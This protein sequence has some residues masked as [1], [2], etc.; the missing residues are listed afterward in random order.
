VAH[1]TLSVY[2]SC[3]PS[4]SLCVCVAH[5][6][7]RSMKDGPCEQV[8]KSVNVGGAGVEVALG[9]GILAPRLGMPGFRPDETRWLVCRK[10]G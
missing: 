6:Y 4:G 5:V 7:V 2:P 9:D 1:L 8:L 3:W 10:Q